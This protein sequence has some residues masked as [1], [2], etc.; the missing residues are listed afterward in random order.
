MRKENP[1]KGDVFL[2]L[3]DTATVV[4]VRRC[5]CGSWRVLYRR[6]RSSWTNSVHLYEIADKF[7]HGPIPKPEN[8]P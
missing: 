5:G 6:G 1:K 7:I 2:Y 4:G 3:G 8:V